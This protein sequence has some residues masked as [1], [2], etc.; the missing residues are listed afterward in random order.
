MDNVNLTTVLEQV[1][2]EKNISTEV[3][4]D[5]VEQAVLTAAKRVFP[6]RE[7][8]PRFD[9][10]TGHV[11]L[12]QVLYV[13]DN[14]ELAMR[15]ISLEQAQRSGIEADIGDELLFPIYYLDRE[16]APVPPY[17]ARRDA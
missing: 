6:D 8:E 3:L 5:T 16:L 4:I 17:R 12:H 7:I 10:E 9:P 14:V 2:K 13:V 11:Q 1:C 15:E